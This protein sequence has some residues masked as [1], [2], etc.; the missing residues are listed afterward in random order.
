[1][2][3]R[4]SVA[5]METIGRATIGLIEYAGAVAVQFWRSLAGMIQAQ[6]F[7]GR[8]L[9]WKSALSQMVAVGVDAV[10]LV[11]LLGFCSGLILAFQGGSELRKL[12]ALDFVV[13]LVALGMMREAG[14]LITAISVICRSGSAFSAEIGA[15]VV[16]GEIDTL[17]TMAVKPVT[18]LVSPKYLALLMMIPCLTIVADVAGILAGGLFVYDAVGMRLTLYIRSVLDA[19]QVRDVVS[20]FIKS[21]ISATVIAQV[22]CMEGF[23]VRGG[24]ESVGHAAT[25]AVVRATYLLLVADMLFA[26]IFYAMSR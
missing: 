13:T 12:G 23:R 1:L 10:P 17:E 11:A 2:N 8:R 16:T 19:L 24:P 4:K 21:V 26:A 15:M 22:G 7:T 18:V 3:N 9:W 14:P 5:A 20:G 25:S 6:P